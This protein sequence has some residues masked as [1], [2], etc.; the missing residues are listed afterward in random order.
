VETLGGK[1]EYRDLE[2][3]LP[4]LVLVLKSYIVQLSFACALILQGGS[5]S[6]KSPVWTS[7][8]LS[9][10][11]GARNPGTP[12]LLDPNRAGLVYL[13]A[14]RL[15]VHETDLVSGLSSRASPNIQSAFLLHAVILDTLTGKI[16]DTK[17]WPTRSRDSAIVVS[18]GAV[19]VRTG[20][21]LR[22]F[23]KDFDPGVE[24]TIASPSSGSA[25]SGVVKDIVTSVTGNT[26]LVN[27]YNS[28]L[29]S[30][31][32][33]VLD[34]NTLK[35]KFFWTESPPLLNLYAA[36]DAQIAAVD[37]PQKHLLV[38]PFGTGDRK[39]FGDFNG[40]PCR[41]VLDTLVWATEESIVLSA[42]KKLL[43]VSKTGPPQIL[44]VFAY[45]ERATDKLQV[46]QDGKFAVLEIDFVQTKRRPFVEDTETIVAKKL[47]VYDLALHK[48]VLT[49]PIMPMPQVDFDFALSPKGS[50]LAVLTDRRVS[51]FEVFHN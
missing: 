39:P 5:T 18:S 7:E 3:S 31:N 35:K 19:L 15:L 43:L 14:N 23:S 28:K 25:P 50:Q 42:C 10:L 44:D 36:S 4:E 22:F 34:G 24:V 8:V 12:Q 1:K 41:G 2:F 16:L 17:D 32:L 40:A 27:A 46:S 9:D 30:S 47:A 11:T 49:I 13:D 48:R 20:E 29:L 45:A 26:I 37:S 21:V 38:A 33:M 6:P 51:M